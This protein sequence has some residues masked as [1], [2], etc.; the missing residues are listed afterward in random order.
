MTMQS[1]YCALVDNSLL[2]GRTTRL[3]PNAVTLVGRPDSIRNP[4]W[5]FILV[6][7]CN[8]IKY[9]I[10]TGNE[11]VDNNYAHDHLSLNKRVT[12]DV[13]VDFGIHTIERDPNDGLFV[14]KVSQQL[15]K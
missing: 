12:R 6:S 4:N 11:T 3:D 8:P 7:A 2:P 14:V 15:S 5:R 13:H 10:I 9:G 1:Q